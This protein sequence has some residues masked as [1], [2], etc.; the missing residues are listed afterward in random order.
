M[1]IL[2][3]KIAHEDKGDGAMWRTLFGSGRTRRGL[4]LRFAVAFLC[5]CFSHGVAYGQGHSVVLTWVAPADATS[6]TTYNVY[7]LSGACPATAP[8]TTSGFTKIATGTTAAVTYT[9]STVA[10]GSYCYIVTDV[11]A[12]VESKP[13]ND[14]VAAILPLPP[15]S[16]VV[17]SAN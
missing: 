9:D 12:G 2:R 6:A 17:T 14:V 13:S 15:G 10:P 1:Q 4:V 5:L 11:E 8:T 3:R 16:L 7:R